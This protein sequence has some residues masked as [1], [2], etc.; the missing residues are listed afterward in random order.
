MN[1]NE[2]ARIIMLGNLCDSTPN[3]I[4]R[5][6]LFELAQS[7]IKATEQPSVAVADE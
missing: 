4:A 7:A 2:I 1:E 5:Q 3:E 6:I